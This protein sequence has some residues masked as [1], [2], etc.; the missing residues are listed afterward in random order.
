LSKS[1]PLPISPTPQAVT[2]VSQTRHRNARFTTPKRSDVDKWAALG[3]RRRNYRS[4]EETVPRLKKQRS[5]N[6]SWRR[7]SGP[8][9]PQ[10]WRNPFLDKEWRPK[11]K[12]NSDYHGSVDEDL[13]LVGGWHDLHL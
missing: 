8:S 9:S 12:L 7:D 2:P 6:L 1:M 5:M 10:A 13:D 11:A 4:D 3:D